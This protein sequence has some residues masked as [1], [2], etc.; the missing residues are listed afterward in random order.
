M[1]EWCIKIALCVLLEKSCQVKF[2]EIRTTPVI[3]QGFSFFQS[4]ENFTL[5]LGL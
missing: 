2:S 5:D 1:I 3:G 4:P